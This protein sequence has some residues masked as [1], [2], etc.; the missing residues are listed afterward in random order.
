MDIQ[1]VNGSGDLD[2]STDALVL[3]D[4]LDGIRQDLTSRLRTFLGE[5]F[6]DQN[7]GIPFFREFLVKNPNQR[8]VRS[9]LREVILD[10]QGI[11]EIQSLEIELDTTTR[12]LGVVLTAKILESVSDETFV[13]VY[14]ELIIGEL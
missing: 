14:N 11:Q 4:G 6:L 12:T 13:Y 1:L 2:D 5:W 3:T 9:V 10:T 7:V 8:V